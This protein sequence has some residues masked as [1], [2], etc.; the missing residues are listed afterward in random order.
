MNDRERLI[1][2]IEQAKRYANDTIGSMNG[3]FAAWYADK[4]ME[5]GVVIVHGWIPVADRLPE[6][7]ERVLT[8]D[9]YGHIRDRVLRKA[10]GS[11]HVYA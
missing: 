5:S 11:G 10:G 3:G 4:L 1:E 9:R 6:Y 8:Y 7:G 2:T